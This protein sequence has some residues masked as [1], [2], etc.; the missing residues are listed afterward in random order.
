MKYTDEIS[1]YKYIKKIHSLWVFKCSS[2][3][4]LRKWVFSVDTGAVIVFFV[5][6]M[7]SYQNV[8]CVLEWVSIRIRIGKIK[9][10]NKK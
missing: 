7:S 6:T 3:Y 4:Q 5:N 2:I 10:I 1:H 8:F 9:T